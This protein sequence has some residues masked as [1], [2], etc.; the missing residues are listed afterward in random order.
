MCRKQWDLWEYDNVT[1]NA[2][3]VQL[4]VSRIPKNKTCG[5]DLLV[6]EVWATAIAADS[7]QAAHMVWAT[8]QR[9][10]N[11]PARLSADR[12]MPTNTWPQ[13]A[14]HAEHVRM[15][16]TSHARIHAPMPSPPYHAHRTT[17]RAHS[18]HSWTATQH[19]RQHHM[20]GPA[21]HTTAPQ[22]HHIEHEHSTRRPTERGRRTRQG[23]WKT[24]RPEEHTTGGRGGRTRQPNQRRDRGT[25]G[26]SRRRRA[27][28]TR[29]EATRTPEIP[30]SVSTCACFPR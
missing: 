29:G 18:P 9:I 21:R 5:R 25:T 19:T 11:V 20:H 28:T 30:G 26:S 1:V 23:G 10:A 24:R 14:K 16:T 2:E 27:S 7:R 12:K 15:D 17:P 22:Y 3:D 13:L 4:L 8:N 6:T